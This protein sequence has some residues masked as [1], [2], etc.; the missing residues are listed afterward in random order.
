[1]TG[2]LIQT[3]NRWESL[4]KNCSGFD[5]QP[6]TACL[7]ILTSNSNTIT[8]NLQHNLKFASHNIKSEFYSIQITL[9]KPYFTFFRLVYPARVSNALR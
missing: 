2:D 3:E 5:W 6:F 1:M 4:E 7:N 8:S 9:K